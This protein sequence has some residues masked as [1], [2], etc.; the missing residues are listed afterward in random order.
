MFIDDSV[1]CPCSER[2][3]RSPCR[4][5]GFK[6]SGRRSFRHAVE[7]SQTFADAEI[8]TWQDI[9][10]SQP[11]DQKHLGRPDP[12]ATNR[13][14]ILDDSFIGSRFQSSERQ[15][16]RFELYGQFSYRLFLGSGNPIA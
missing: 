9:Q 11:E 15:L 6:L 4:T 13:D 14:E 1:Q 5:T 8:T 3:V 2:P 16:S 10:S 7:Y 12:D